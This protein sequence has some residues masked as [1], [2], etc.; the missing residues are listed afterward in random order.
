MRMWDRSRTLLVAT[1]AWDRLFAFRGTCR[2]T[3]TV[4]SV[5]PCEPCAVMEKAGASGSCVRVT[6]GT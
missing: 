2:S 6:F 1:M 4:S 5:L 3:M